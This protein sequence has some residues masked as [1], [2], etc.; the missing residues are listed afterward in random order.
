MLQ[1]TLI[2]LFGLIFIVLGVR[3][4]VTREANFSVNLWGNRDRH[5]HGDVEHFVEGFPAILIGLFEIGFGIY[6][7]I[8]RHTPW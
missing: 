3:S 2:L 1:K 8:Y 6:I 5:G 4:I 7:L